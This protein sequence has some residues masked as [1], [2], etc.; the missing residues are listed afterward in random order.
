MDPGKRTRT[1]YSG[2]SQ[3]EKE[4][5]NLQRKKRRTTQPSYSELPQEKK[6]QLNARKR[7]LRR[8]K[9]E[10]KSIPLPINIPQ[11]ANILDDS[12]ATTT[13]NLQNGNSVHLC[14]TAP[15]TYE[16]GTF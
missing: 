4:N 8:L 14:V 15:S 13:S 1:P 6:D 3:E 9:K 16:I 12:A 2:L 11:Y 10:K 5:R 7:E